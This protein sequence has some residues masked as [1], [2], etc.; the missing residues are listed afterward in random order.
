M[1]IRDSISAQTRETVCRKA[2]E[3]GYQ[4]N[5]AARALKKMCIR[6]SFFPS[7]YRSETACITENSSRRA[8]S[9][10]VPSRTTAGALTPVSYTHL[11][12]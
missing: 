9:F 8:A 12:T 7:P 2:A 11:R 5:S 1:C 3:M 4:P 6:D 10:N